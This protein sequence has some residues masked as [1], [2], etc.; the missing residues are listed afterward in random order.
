[1]DNFESILQ[2]IKSP[3]DL[4]TL[5]DEELLKLCG[6]LRTYLVTH[7][8]ET[9]GHLASNLGVV[10][11]SVALHQVFNT[12]SDHLIWDVGHQC[13]IHKL[14]T[15]RQDRFDTIRTPGGL[16]G[17]PKRSES[18]YDAFGAGHSST[19]ISAALGFAEA[20]RLSGND[21]YTVA[22]VGDGA[23]TGGLIHEA[24]NNINKDLPLVII[25]NENEMSISPIRG[26]FSDH[27]AKIRH[28]PR[29]HKTKK[30]TRRFIRRI[31]LIGE[32]TFRGIR[33]AKQAAKNFLYNSNYFEDMGLYYLGPIDGND[34]VTVRDM[35]KE[36]KSEHQATILHIKTVKGKGYA[37]AESSPN[38]YHGILPGNKPAAYNF[39]AEVG[40]LLCEQAKTDKTVCAITAAM[41]EGCGIT[42]F[43][44]R[45]PDRFFDVGIAEEHAL[46]FAAGL[47]ARGMRPVFTVY[48]TFLQRGYDNLIHDIALQDLPV[49]VCIDRAGLAAGDGPTHHGIFDVAFLG[50][51]P[52]IPLWA[53][54]DFTSLNRAL[55]DSLK[56]GHPACIRYPN[57]KPLDEALFPY[58]EYPFRQNFTDAS[59][60][61]A[62]IV[63]YGRIAEEAL[64]A[65]VR[66]K[67]EGITCGVLLCEQLLP[68]AAPAD[69]L[70][71]VLGGN[72]TPL[73]VLEEGVKM[74]GLGMMLREALHD[75]GMTN[76][77]EIAAI[78]DPFAASETGRKLIATLG[79][80]REAVAEKVRKMLK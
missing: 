4:R 41:A 1:M 25:L 36:A 30:A 63:T 8:T 10:E 45:Y 39:S 16:S 76:R 62:L 74:G 64:T 48:S 68:I 20:D 33:R 47:A 66:L 50:Q 77:L 61:D 51:I 7:V 29:Y 55:D 73:L 34:F 21:A 12:P 69:A 52:C 54:A 46:V 43:A 38:E 42:D 56:S 26:R 37:P 6:E 70:E 60:L 75:R 24:L 57:A 49:T 27:L 28:S 79:I 40:R 15:G 17:F 19:S 44:A 67:A 32:A 71:K 72:D 78:E 9:G 22:I 58:G 35:L 80:D 11:L 2:Q 59:Q 31:P 3:A 13:Y 5:S 18:E 23:F 65:A 14:L 53:P